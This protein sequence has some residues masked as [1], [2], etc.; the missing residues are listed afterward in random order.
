[1]VKG[2]VDTWM[3]E[4]MKTDV[5]LVARWLSS[6]KFLRLC[7][8]KVESHP[9][10]RFWGKPIMKSCVKFTLS[11]NVFWKA[12]RHFSGKSKLYMCPGYFLELQV[13]KTPWVKQMEHINPFKTMLNQDTESGVKYKHP[14]NLP[15]SL[16]GPLHGNDHYNQNF[17][18]SL[19]SHALIPLRPKG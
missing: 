14:N 18:C 10:N 4:W 1:M 7:H 2:C 3:P 13:Q 6:M 8:C 15:F 16:P 19:S 9:R 5:N 17:I 12:N 11:A